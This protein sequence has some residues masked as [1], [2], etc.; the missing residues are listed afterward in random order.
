VGIIHYM[1]CGCN[2]ATHLYNKNAL[3]KQTINNSKRYPRKGP[4]PFSWE[5]SAEDAIR[6]AGWDSYTDWSVSG[7]LF[8]FEKYNG[9]GYRNTDVNSPYLWNFSNHYTPLFSG[10]RTNRSSERTDKCGAA[11]ILWRMF[12][13][14][15]FVFESIDIFL[16]LKILSTD[17]KFSTESFSSQAVELQQLL[18]YLGEKVLVDGLPGRQTSDAFCKLFGS[19]LRFDPHSN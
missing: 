13:R 6:L 12:E 8:Q 3:Q 16:R 9:F 7:T 4:A 11:V 15:L 5:Y 10:I 2:F 17:I 19:F 1:E 14:G 18:N